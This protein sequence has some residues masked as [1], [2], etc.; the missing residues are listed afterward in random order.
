VDFSA[1]LEDEGRIDEAVTAAD[2]HGLGAPMLH[3]LMLAHDWLGLP[4]AAR[5][6]ARARASAAVR[7]LDRILAHLYAGAAWHVMPS[8]GTLASLARYGLWQRLYRISLKA[9]WRYRLDQARRE[10]FTPADWDTL[11]LPDALFVLYP[12][13]RP[14]AWLVRRLR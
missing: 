12:V 5:H 4:V 14:F 7:R 9:D 13:V 2:A 1:A 3:A 11:R 10:W 6:L 8:R